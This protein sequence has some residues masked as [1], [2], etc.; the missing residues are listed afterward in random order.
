MKVGLWR[1]RCELADVVSDMEIHSVISAATGLDV[2]NV[3]TERLEGARHCY[4]NLALVS[5][6][7][8]LDLVR[9]A[10]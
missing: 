10:I 4:R 9:T 7:E 8:N 5:T 1:R 3:S 2:F 6:K